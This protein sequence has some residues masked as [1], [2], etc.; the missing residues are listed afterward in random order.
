MCWDVDIVHRPYSEL[1][2]ADYWLRLGI[3][4]DFDPLFREYLEYTCHLCHS[5]PAPTDLLMRPKNMPYYRGPRFQCTTPTESNNADTL[6]IQSLLTDI[7]TS[8]DWGHTHLSNVPIHVGQLALAVH[9]ATSSQTLLNLELA[10]YSRQA[11]QYNWAVYSFSN[12]HF[13]SLIKS[14]GLALHYLP[15]M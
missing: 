13:S 5:N 7:T 10:L 14:H 3:D 11:M 1:V 12:G 8:T 2:D 15:C 4:I 6:H 9:T